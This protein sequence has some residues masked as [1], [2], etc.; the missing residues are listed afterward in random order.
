M[1][2]ENSQ[3]ITLNDLQV[4]QLSRELSSSA[5]EIYQ[6][7]E[8][9]LKWG[10][11]QQFI[12]S[13]DSIGANVAEGYGRFHY[14]DKVRFY[15]QARGSYFESM[16]HWLELLLERKLIEQEVFDKLKKIGKEL[17]IKLN[18][19]VKATIKAKEKSS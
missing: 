11:G 1:S 15:Y 12:Q 3:Y 17:Q 6:S 13:V 14:L 4:Y 16:E 18:L 10:I 2:T 8:K 19:L 7:L 5:W 9:D